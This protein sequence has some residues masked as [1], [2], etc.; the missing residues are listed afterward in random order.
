MYR[1][2]FSWSRTRHQS[3][4]WQAA[5]YDTDRT[6]Y[7]ELQFD[8]NIDINGQ[9]WEQFCSCTADASFELPMETCNFS[10]SAKHSDTCNIPGCL[11][12]PIRLNVCGS[13]RVYA[14]LVT[15]MPAQS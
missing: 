4:A 7:T 6:G 10:L 2:V 15:S 8:S 12:I 11:Q 14:V 9:A 5:Q 1:Q 13:K 3:N